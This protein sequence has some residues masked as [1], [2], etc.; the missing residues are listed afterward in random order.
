LGAG[1][2]SDASLDGRVPRCHLSIGFDSL[3]ASLLDH[4]YTKC[5]LDRSTLELRGLHERPGADP[6]LWRKLN[7]DYRI[8]QGRN[9]FTYTDQPGDEVVASNISFV[10]IVHI[11]EVFVAASLLRTGTR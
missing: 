1:G 3:S 6:A 5:P 8:W 9:I 2:L 4:A 11:V 10:T 7:D